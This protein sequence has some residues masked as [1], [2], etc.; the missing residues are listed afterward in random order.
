MD[1][2]TPLICGVNPNLGKILYILS[3][4]PIYI[5]QNLQFVQTH[6]YGNTITGHV[7]QAYIQMDAAHAYWRTILFEDVANT[8]R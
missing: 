7:Y 5:L 4:Y 8:N 3:K 6:S 1:L 2:L